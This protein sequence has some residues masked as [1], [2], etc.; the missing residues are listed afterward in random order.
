MLHLILSIYLIKKKQNTRY[1]E[2]RNN[3]EYR[4]PFLVQI[5]TK[6]LFSG[7]LGTVKVWM[8]R[9][10]GERRLRRTTCIYCMKQRG[11]YLMLAFNAYFAEVKS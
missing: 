2:D 3:Q 4:I 11:A 10:T 7:T 6:L 1:R 8:Y 9:K 5:R